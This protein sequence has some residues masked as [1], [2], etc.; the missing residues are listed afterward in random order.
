MTYNYFYKG[1]NIYNLT[2]SNGNQTVPGFSEF[3]LQLA[4][5]VQPQYTST[6]TNPF[7]LSY[8]YQSKDVANYCTAYNTGPLTTPG[9]ITSIDIPGTN[10]VIT[11]KHISAYGWGGGGGGGGGGGIV[12]DGNAYNAGFG[13]SGSPGNYAGTVQAA[14]SSNI[15]NY[16]VGTGGKGGGGG[17]TNDTLGKNAGDGGNGGVGNST[18]LNINGTIIL[19]AQG[20]SGG[21]GGNGASCTNAPYK[22]GNNGTTPSTP[23]SSVKSGNIQYPPVSGAPV[24]VWPAQTNGNAGSGGI[25]AENYSPGPQKSAKSGSAGSPGYLQIYFLYDG[26]T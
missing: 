24:L 18:T 6:V 16:T 2:Q 14:I 10:P 13:A 17:A 21:N 22:S 3:P 7:P 15:I 12:K 20:G 23:A 4:T 1:V 9:S 26:T 8:L 5:N 11:Y 19:T 25:A